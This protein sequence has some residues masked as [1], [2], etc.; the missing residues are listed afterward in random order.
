MKSSLLR[1]YAANLDL[2]M[3]LTRDIPESRMTEQ[4]ADIMN[5]PAWV[6]GHLAESTD[7]G[8]RCLGGSPL[9]PPGYKSLFDIGTKPA[10]DLGIYP[11]K[12][13]LTT[14]VNEAHAALAEAFEK[15]ADSLLEMPL[16]D[17]GMRAYWP[18]NA[19]L[20][21]FLMA[22]HESIHLGQLSAWRRASNLPHV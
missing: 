17:Q 5:H 3:R 20:I 6:L 7:Y 13:Q 12:T 2:A 10:S 15:A 9:C 8:L 21:L 11:S 22:N 1:A 18:T 4:P 14:R 19:D 16:A